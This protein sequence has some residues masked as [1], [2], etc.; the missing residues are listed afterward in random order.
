M[1]RPKTKDLD[2]ALLPAA[3]LVLVSI[4][5]PDNV[6]AGEGAEIDLRNT[7]RGDTDFGS[8]RFNR[9]TGAWADFAI[10]GFKG[11]GLCLLKSMVEGITLRKAVQE[12]EA[13]DTAG[14]AAPEPEKPKK[15]VPALRIVEPE[16][17]RNFG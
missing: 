3:E 12:L 10:E 11:H 5:G 1:P 4:L 15:Q 17:F 14:F 13:L 2:A 8:F 7:R 16:E 9:E 6:R